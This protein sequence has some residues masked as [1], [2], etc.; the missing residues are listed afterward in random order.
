MLILHLQD[1]I[2]VVLH[3]IM[4]LEKKFDS[5]VVSSMKGKLMSHEY[6]INLWSIVHQPL[7]YK[8]IYEFEM[9]KTG[10]QA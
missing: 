10:S 7:V 1:I 3:D 9:L 6:D 5:A 2:W 4:V 8:S